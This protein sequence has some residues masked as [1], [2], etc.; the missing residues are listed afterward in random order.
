LRAVRLMSNNPE[1]VDAVERAGIA[2]VERVPCIADAVD[3]REAYC[4]PR[5]KD[6]HLLEGF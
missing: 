5:K 6:G 4:A 2:V 1:K 3:S